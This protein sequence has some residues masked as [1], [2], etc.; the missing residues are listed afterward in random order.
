MLA[1]V[2]AAGRLSGA[3]RLAPVSNTRG[4]ESKSKSFAKADTDITT[5]KRRD[6]SMVIAR[7]GVCAR[8][9]HW[10]ALTGSLDSKA[11]DRNH[12]RRALLVQDELDELIVRVG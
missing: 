12:P 5:G 11:A 2:M 8:W 1:P 6:W 4:C 10:S 7:D 3:L 9:W